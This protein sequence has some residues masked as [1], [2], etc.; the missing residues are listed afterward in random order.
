MNC[1]VK[2]ARRRTCSSSGES[3]LVLANYVLRIRRNGHFRAS[4]K[5]YD[6]VIRFSD[7]G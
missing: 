7:T 2:A 3:G 4:G 1:N 5:N 6:I